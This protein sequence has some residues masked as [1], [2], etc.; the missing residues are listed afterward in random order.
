MTTST[1]GRCCR[2]AKC[3]CVSRAPLSHLS[4]RTQLIGPRAGA[5][6]RGGAR[7]AAVRRV[8]DHRLRRLPRLPHEVLRVPAAAAGALCTRSPRVRLPVTSQPSEQGLPARSRQR[9]QE[10]PPVATGAPHWHF[11]PCH[12]FSHTNLK[13]P[14]ARQSA[15]RAEAPVHAA[16]AGRAQVRSSNLR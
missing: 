15:G 6:A 8:A 4:N 14:C 7:A 13:S 16:T 2:C 12:S 3:V 11:L 9:L 10:R 5:V 1:K